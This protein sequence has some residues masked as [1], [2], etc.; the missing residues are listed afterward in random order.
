MSTDLDETFLC[1]EGRMNVIKV[2][3]F[4]TVGCSYVAVFVSSVPGIC[5][6]SLCTGCMVHGG[7][8][9]PSGSISRNL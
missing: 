9:P 5:S 7:S 1:V 8:Y 4:Q 6:V 2:W 3:T